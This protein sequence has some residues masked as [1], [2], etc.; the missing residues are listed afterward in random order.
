MAL[1]Y[2]SP[3]GT[4][5][6]RRSATNNEQEKVTRDHASKHKPEADDGMVKQLNQSNAKVKDN[7]VDRTHDSS[8]MANKAKT[9]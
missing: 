2:S 5:P 6:P 8:T 3:R 1:T 7:D 4:S 9:D